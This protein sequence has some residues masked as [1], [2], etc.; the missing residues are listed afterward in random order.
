MTKILKD[1][2]AS[3]E[4]ELDRSMKQILNWKNPNKQYFGRKETLTK[5]LNNSERFLSLRN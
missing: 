3:K 5:D 1:E 2:I 4:N